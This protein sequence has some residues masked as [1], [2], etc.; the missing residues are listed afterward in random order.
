AARRCAGST[1]TP[2]VG[3]VPR[4]RRRPFEPAG[5]AEPWPPWTPPCACLPRP[6]GGLAGLLPHVLAFVPNALALVGLRLADLPDV[7]GHLADLL[8]VYAP[9]HDPGRRRHLELDAGRRL[10]RDRV[11]KPQRKL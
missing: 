8:L 4:S 3:A 2:R 7:G 9:D 6:L 11:G 1:G 10:D 5:D